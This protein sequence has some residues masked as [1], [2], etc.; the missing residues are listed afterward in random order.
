MKKVDGQLEDGT[1][2]YIGPVENHKCATDLSINRFKYTGRRSVTCSSITD[3]VACRSRCDS[4]AACVASF[5]NNADPVRKCVI[6]THC[7]LIQSEGITTYFKSFGGV[8]VYPEARINTNDLV[9][10]SQKTSPQACVE[11]CKKNQACI[12]ARVNAIVGYETYSTGICNSAANP[13]FNTCEHYTSGDI[14]L[15]MPFYNPSE[16]DWANAGTS[17][18]NFGIVYK[19]RELSTPTESST[20]QPPPVSKPTP[21]VPT[22]KPTTKKPT[23]PTNPTPPTNIPTQKPS[24]ASPTTSSPTSSDNTVIIASVVPVAVILLIGG[25]FMWVKRFR[26]DWLY[27]RLGTS[28]AHI[29]P[30]I[31]IIPKT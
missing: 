16:T 6:I 31:S 28:D 3:E 10:T 11:N 4:E 30:E 8:E 14:N 25:G 13:M 18:N 24:L 27:H 1:G 9:I 2:K 15:D 20:P 29:T 26:P 5:L 7:D 23:S 12:Y 21:R 17:M 22:K 19:V